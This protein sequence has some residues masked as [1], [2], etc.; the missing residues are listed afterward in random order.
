M[1]SNKNAKFRVKLL[2]HTLYIRTIYFD[3]NMY[4]NELWRWVASLGQHNSSP[5]GSRAGIL[6]TIGK[7]VAALTQ[8]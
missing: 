8:S 5:Q 3:N 2:F 7:T 6:Y 1:N 4:N